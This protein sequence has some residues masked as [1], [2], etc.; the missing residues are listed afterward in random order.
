MDERQ[1]E[2]SIIKLKERIPINIE[3]KQTL[4]KEFLK[5]KRRFPWGKWGALV[6]AAL[7]IV[8]VFTYQGPTGIQGVAAEKLQVQ[9]Q[10]SF[11]DI[12]SGSPLG[13]SEHQGTVYIP[14]FGKGLFAYD[15][16]GFHSLLEKD[17]TDAKIDPS[18]TKVVLS[19]GG[20]IGL[21]DVGKEHYQELLKGDGMLVSY[22]Q[23]SWKNENTILFVQKIME[24]SPEHGF[25][26]KE[27]TIYEMNIADLKLKKL[28]EGASPSYVNGKKEIVLEKDSKVMLKDLKSGKETVLDEGRFP[29]VSAN[30]KY[31]SYVKTESQRREVQKNAFIEE[32]VDQI[33]IAD[34]DGKTKKVVT[35]NTPH[36]YIS[37]QDWLSQLQPSNVPQVLTITGLYSYYN[38]VW[39]SDS[40]SIYVLKNQN[41]EG[42]RMRIM[43]IDLAEEALSEKEVVKVFNQ[44]TIRRDLDFARSLLKNNQEFFIP[45]NPHPVHFSVVGTGTEGD[46]KYVDVEE[47]WAYTANPYYSIKNVRYFLE[48]KDHGYLI[49]EMKDLQDGVEVGEQN[50]G[51]I[52]ITKAGQTEILFKKETIPQE[53]LPKGD[54][55]IASLAYLPHQEKVVFGLQVLQDQSVGQSSSVKVIVYDKKENSFTLKETI[56]EMAGMKNIGVENIIVSPN[57]KYAAL[58]LFSDDDKEF[59]SQVLVMDLEKGKNQFLYE[60]MPNTVIESTHTHYWDGEKLHFTLTSNGQEMNYQWDAAKEQVELP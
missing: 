51:S 50:D 15:Q 42:S 28:G 43:R 4:R 48:K 6:A 53:L 54:F 19:A 22:E 52:V 23:P 30:G 10:V 32:S 17:I 21:F 35:A 13:V 26:V 40:E 58:D 47:N 7:L 45:S 39:S 36:Y 25:T 34:I 38:P 20:A 46:R 12:G 24:Q 1:V 11:V 56:T 16:N 57:G 14:V 33:W 9:N 44:A 29:S 18:G 41:M 5:K 37:E 2:E 49:S 31:I 60:K 55:R 8:G 59:R 3:L 27:S